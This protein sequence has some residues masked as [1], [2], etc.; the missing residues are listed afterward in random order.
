MEATLEELISETKKLLKNPGSGGR[1]AWLEN[2]L[3]VMDILNKLKN[4]INRT[5]F[6][7]I[8]E[9]HTGIAAD[10]IETTIDYL[11]GWNAIKVDGEN[12]VKRVAKTV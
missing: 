5:E 8:T 11:I 12:I 2:R 6:V 1:K 7:A 10:S 4:P 9:R 3:A